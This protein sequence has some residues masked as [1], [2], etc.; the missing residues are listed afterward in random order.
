MPDQQGGECPPT[1]AIEHHRSRSNSGGNAGSVRGRKIDNQS[2]I[3]VTGGASHNRNMKTNIN[4][5]RVG[6][7]NLLI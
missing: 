3:L 5:Y 6:Q 4:K 1:A 2:D 7:I